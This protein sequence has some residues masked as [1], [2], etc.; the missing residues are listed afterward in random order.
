MPIRDDDRRRAYHRDYM[1]RRRAGLTGFNS[2]DDQS[3]PP[4]WSE[5][6]AKA[7]II[8]H[9][10]RLEAEC[11]GHVRAHNELVDAYNALAD[12]YDALVDDY[13]ALLARTVS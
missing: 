6:L 4:G 10:D 13:D 11:D 1:R 3:G 5:W 12:D 8:L 7:C 2:T 9:I